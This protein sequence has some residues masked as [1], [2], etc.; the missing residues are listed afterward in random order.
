MPKKYLITLSLIESDDDDG[1]KCIDERLVV[2]VHNSKDRAYLYFE[3]AAKI[4][5]AMAQTIK[6]GVS[7]P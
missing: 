2:T 3:D 1:D 5:D 4:L 7:L 6:E